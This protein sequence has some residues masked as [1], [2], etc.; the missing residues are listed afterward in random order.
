MKNI[1]TL[2]ALL[3]L[4]GILGLS[5]APVMADAVDEDLPVPLEDPEDLNE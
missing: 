2:L 1:R 3:L 5:A 4:A